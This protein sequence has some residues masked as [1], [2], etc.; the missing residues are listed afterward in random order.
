MTKSYEIYT[1]STPRT[2]VRTSDTNT[3]EAGQ[4]AITT[5]AALRDYGQLFKLKGTADY[6]MVKAADDRATNIANARA[7]DTRIAAE[8]A[9]FWGAM[10][11]QKPVGDSIERA[12][13]DKE[14]Y[15]RQTP[16]AWNTQ[17]KIDADI[18]RVDAKLVE[19]RAKIVAI[20]EEAEPF[21]D[22]ARK[23]EKNEYKGWNRFFL[24]EHIHS[25][26]H[27]SSF[28]ENTKIGWLPDVSGLTEAEAVKEHGAILCT[29]CFPTA[30]TDWTKGLSPEE[31]GYCAGSGKQHSTEHL[32]GRENQYYSPAGYCPECLQWNTLTRTG[33]LRKHKV[34]ETKRSAVAK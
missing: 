28:R 34:S 6:K 12:L 33:A 32:T 8:W 27:C 14:Y 1:K 17:E 4:I 10:A 7:V 16:T 2:W 15:T 25:S 26:Q 29:I 20:R 31:Q 11:Q 3:V 13:K 19:L 22:A 5:T 24:V 18:A 21:A 9:K 23:I 30:P